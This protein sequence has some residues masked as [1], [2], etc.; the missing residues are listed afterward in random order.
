MLIWLYFSA[1][2]APEAD[3]ANCVIT[4]NSN[5]WA[6]LIKR[7]VARRSVQKVLTGTNFMLR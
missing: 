6:A 3:A 2:A 5:K 4:E 1:K 7:N